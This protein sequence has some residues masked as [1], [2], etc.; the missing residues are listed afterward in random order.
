MAVTSSSQVVP[1]KEVQGGR[2]KVNPAHLA[3]KGF[4]SIKACV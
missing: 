1:V 4:A 3:W 2:R